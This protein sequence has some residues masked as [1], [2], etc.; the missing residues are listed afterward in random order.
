[1]MILDVRHPCMLN[2]HQ[3]LRRLK[4]CANALQPGLRHTY[5]LNKL[6]KYHRSYNRACSRLRRRRQ[7][8][9]RD[10]CSFLKDLGMR[11]PE[12]AVQSVPVIGFRSEE[13]AKEWLFDREFSTGHLKYEA[14]KKANELRH[15]ARA[16]SMARGDDRFASDVFRAV[17]I[18]I[19]HI[20][21]RL[22]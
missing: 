15:Y 1:M 2:H 4:E 20:R 19:H 7:A 12:F 11:W 13:H 8:T 16:F 10:L 5:I 22:R 6:W 14:L 21:Y 3:M 9:D 17:E 18:A